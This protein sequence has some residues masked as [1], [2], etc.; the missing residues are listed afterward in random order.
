MIWYILNCK[1]D[2]HHIKKNVLNIFT[3]KESLTSLAG[4]QSPQTVIKPIAP[5]LTFASKSGKI[6]TVPR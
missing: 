1:I 3:E 6:I 4:I 2:K 5:S